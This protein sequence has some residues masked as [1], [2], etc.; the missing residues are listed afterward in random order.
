MPGTWLKEEVSTHWNRY[1][2]LIDVAEENERL[3]EE[4]NKTD[5][6]LASIRD[7]LAELSRLR[8]LV[9][10]KPP[11]KWRTLGARVLAGRFGPG[12]S[13]E[14]VMID[15]GFSTGAPPGTP[16]ITPQGLVGRVFRAS[17]HISTVLL[18][19]DQSFR[20]AVVT[21]E[22]RV[23][24]VIMG[25]GPRANLEVKYLA[26]NVKVEVGELLI[27]SGLDD[28]FPKGL[29]VARIVTVEPGTETLFQQVQAEPLASP[30]SLEEVLLLIAPENWPVHIAM[31][32]IVPGTATPGSPAPDMSEPGTSGPDTS[33]PGPAAR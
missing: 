32:D 33:R 2:A 24:G 21:S 5:Q 22:G 29:P 27:T 13:L 6:Y 31:P 28:T 8:A 11:A 7:D 3:R 26:P 15:R 17:P 23:P 25:G 1:I 14:T 18:L 30:D 19:T 12:A 20:A 9:G 10:V 16:I 4:K